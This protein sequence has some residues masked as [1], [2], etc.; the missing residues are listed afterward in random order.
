MTECAPKWRLFLLLFLISLFA[1]CTQ[2][3]R[4]SVDDEKEPQF[5]EG[6]KRI[7]RMDWD[8]AINAF[9][10][11]LQ[12]NPNNASAHFELGVLY[13]QKK[14]DFISAIYHYHKHLVL[15]TNS[16]MAEMARQ[17]IIGCTRELSKSVPLAI[18][19][20]EVQRDLE[21][22]AQTNT[23]LKTRVEFLEAE[24]LRRPQYI[25]NY[26][27]NFVGVPLEQRS[28]SRLTQPTQLVS[29]PAYSERT[30]AE[31]SNRT[32]S[33]QTSGKQPVSKSSSTK[34]PIP[35]SERRPPEPVVTPSTGV[36]TLHTVR[37]GE[38]LATLAS[39]YGV[40]LQALKAANPAA[41]GGVRSGQKIN[42]PK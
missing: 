14:N 10:H 26:V 12:A 27:T 29:P 30:A 35:L 19:T 41:T 32:E 38:T 31:P 40:S 28:S 20:R 13:D 37:P 36:R 24:L 42:I 6:Q 23:L 2:M 9:E 8:G 1:G 15:R 11:A 33:I 22:L 5:I 34:R 25:T 17:S 21:R 7:K 18:V 3:R 39:R 4:A 16:P